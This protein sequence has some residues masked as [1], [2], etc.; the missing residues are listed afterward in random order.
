[1]LFHKKK[2]KKKNSGRKWRCDLSLSGRAPKWAPAG[3]YNRG[4]FITLLSIGT[5]AH[6]L[7]R[8]GNLKTFQD[9]FYHIRQRKTHCNVQNREEMA[10]FTS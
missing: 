10:L 1:M 9:V 7:A 2:K 3:E 8:W 5:N 6:L 4:V